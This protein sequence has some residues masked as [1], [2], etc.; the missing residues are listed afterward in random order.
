MK[1]IDLLPKLANLDP[2]LIQ[3]IFPAKEVKRRFDS[4]KG[5]ALDTLKAAKCALEDAGD[6]RHFSPELLADIEK[7]SEGM[8]AL[9]LYLA[10][11]TELG[12]KARL[13]EAVFWAEA[14]YLE[15]S[16]FL[17]G[18]AKERRTKEPYRTQISSLP[19]HACMVRYRQVYQIK[20][21]IKNNVE[22][23]PPGKIGSILQQMISS[24]LNQFC[25]FATEAYLQNP[26]HNLA[27][28]HKMLSN[29]ML[30]RTLEERGDRDTAEK[31]YQGARS[32]AVSMDEPDSES[33]YMMLNYI[34]RNYN[35][36]TSFKRL[37]QAHES[38]RSRLRHLHDKAVGI[39]D[40]GGGYKPTEYYS[41]IPYVTMGARTASIAGLVCLFYATTDIGFDN[42][43]KA[44]GFIWDA[45]TSRISEGSE[46]LGTIQN[47][48]LSETGGIARAF[49]SGGIAQVLDTEGIAHF[50]DKFNMLA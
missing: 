4:I 41:V 29:L 30:G 18:A 27:A 7:A 5:T 23:E 44:I 12:S 32:V 43:Q 22:A 10:E 17:A 39:E 24:F 11:P 50:M 16:I 21:W 19:A 3:K 46:T 47:A 28:Y 8:R 49:E 45:V 31:Y 35:E 6:C 14:Q 36:F 1:I 2:Q 38:I 33:H 20:Q 15:R 34:K 13:N 26:R 40:T 48:L 9:Y 37:S 42:M 25:Y